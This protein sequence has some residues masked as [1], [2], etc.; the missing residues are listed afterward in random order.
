MPIPAS[1]IVEVNPRLIA[2]SGDALE[3]N[4]LILTK[5]TDIA[6]NSLLAFYDSS[7]V[8]DY[9]GETSQEASLATIYFQGYENAYKSPSTLLFAHHPSVNCP[10]WLCGGAINTQEIN[11]AKLKEYYNTSIEF[12]ILNTSIILERLDLSQIHSYSDVAIILQNALAD[13]EIEAS[14]EYISYKKA[15]KITLNLSGEASIMG[16]CKGELAQL[17]NLDEDASG[18]ISLGAE[19]QSINS[20]MEGIIAKTQNWVNFTT[21]WQAEK[22]EVLAFATWASSKNVSYLY[23]YADN[24]EK[25]LIADN[26]DTIAYALQEA[27]LSSVAGQYN[28][29]EYC[30]FIMAIGASIDYTRKEGA[31]TTAF[32]SQSGLSAVV[33]TEDKAIALMQNNMNFMGD[34][35]TRNDNFIF[36]YPGQMFG[37][38]KWIDVYWNAIWLNNALQLSLLAGLVNSP[39][40]PYSAKGYALVRAWIQDTI[41]QALNNNVIEAGISLS[42]SQKTQINREAGKIISSDIEKLGYYVQ[43][44]DPSADERVNRQSPTINLWYAYGGSINKLV[45][46]STALV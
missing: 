36:N 10:A 44:V 4:G 29:L 6:N 41:N 35:A 8:S 28:S 22:E 18:Q 39:R 11:I 34:Y 38:Y 33:D 30:A 31:I 19:A 23:L 24:D 16:Y 32:K 17:L 9:F 46:S 3:F 21:A 14:V 25:L 7:S 13:V 43:I 15:F 12:D 1:Q 40:T 26:E 45:V 20:T 27:H 2:S 5:N 37:S 42:E